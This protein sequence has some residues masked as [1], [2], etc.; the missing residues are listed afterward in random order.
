MHRRKQ[1]SQP[2][3]W[4]IEYLFIFSKTSSEQNVNSIVEEKS[5]QVADISFFYRTFNNKKQH[6]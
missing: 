6:L 1:P 5:L 4:M 2:R 3:H